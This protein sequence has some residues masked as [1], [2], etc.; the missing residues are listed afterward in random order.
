MLIGVD[1]DNTIIKYDALFRRLAAEQGLLADDGQMTKKEVRDAL[2][3]KDLHQRWTDIQALVYG[4]RINEA[5]AFPKAL[6][7]FELCRKRNVRT[8][9]V[10]HKTEFA[11]SDTGQTTNLRTAAMGWLKRHGFFADSTPL[12]T[13]DVYFASTRS[14]KVKMIDQFG[15]DVFIDDL[16][17]VF[18]EPGYPVSAHSVL[19]APQ[20][21][22]VE[23][24]G[25]VRT[26]WGEIVD[27][28][29]SW[30]NG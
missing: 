12:G 24:D 20:A 19:F 5:V 13:D 27:R 22:S 18:T 14:E 11:A 29:E 8:C 30:I 17:E 23:F 25:E 3:D 7:F 10:S 6:A 9:I 15:C 2:W 4:P 26:D 1:L 16:I 21:H 28:L